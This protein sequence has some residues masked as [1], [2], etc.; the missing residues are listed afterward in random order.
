MMELHPVLMRDGPHESAW[1]R[2]EPPLVEGDEAHH[3]V[4]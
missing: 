3:V 4:L 2:P 1:R